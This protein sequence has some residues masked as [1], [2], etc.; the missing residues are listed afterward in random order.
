[1]FIT[2]LGTAAPSHSY[3]Q[4][5]CWE[6]FSRSG[7]C[8]RLEP[9]S[10]AIVKKVLTGNNGIV[11]RR[12]ALDR[13]EDAFEVSADALHRRF[14]DNAPALATQAA[15]RALADAEIA[16]NKIDALLLRTCTGYLCPGLTRYV[17][18]RFRL[19]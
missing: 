18:Q 8:E 10:R 12:L 5:E 9:R 7:L 11:T 6:I 13:L 15:E 2:G 17:S 4:R 1:M 19:W 3:S 16:S 14:F